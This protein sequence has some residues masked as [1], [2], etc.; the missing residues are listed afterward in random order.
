MMHKL[1]KKCFVS[2]WTVNLY[3]AVMLYQQSLKML[4]DSEYKVIDY[5]CLPLKMNLRCSKSSIDVVIIFSI[6]NSLGHDNQVMISGTSW[7]TLLV[8]VIARI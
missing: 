7:S 6:I 4:Y 8:H 5:R 1:N 3:W 2:H